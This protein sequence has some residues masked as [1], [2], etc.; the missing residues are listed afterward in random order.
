MSS[1]QVTGRLAP[2]YVQS[3]SGGERRGSKRESG[4][5]LVSRYRLLAIMSRHPVTKIWVSRWESQQEEEQAL[6][7]KE[8]RV[9]N[10]NA[11]RRKPVGPPFSR[12]CYEAAIQSETKSTL[13]QEEKEQR[14]RIYRFDSSR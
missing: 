4:S 10:P 2:C 5:H 3:P 8:E 12:M 7:E 14:S 6:K 9:G 11:F 1:R 13:H